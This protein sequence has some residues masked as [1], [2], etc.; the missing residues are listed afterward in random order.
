[1]RRPIRKVLLFGL[2]L[3]TAGCHTASHAERGALF[4]GLTGAG[5]GAAIGDAS[6][7]A[8]PGAAIGAGIGT[9]AGATIGGDVDQAEAEMHAAHGAVAAQAIN[10]SDVVRMTQAGL[11]DTVIVNQIH[12][13]GSL[14]PPTTDEVIYLQQQGVSAEVIRAYQE[15]PQLVMA[16]P[17]PAT[18]VVVG[19]R[20]VVRG[21]VVAPPPMRVRPV[22]PMHPRRHRFHW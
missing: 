21:V 5:L 18:T 3:L 4:G 11:G 22:M 6:G 20:P 1:M 2:L 13:Q 8:G 19:P 15:A 16:Q 9:L 12:A 17:T 14:A 7:H 10:V